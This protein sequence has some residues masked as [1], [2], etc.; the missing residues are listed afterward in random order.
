MCLKLSR[1]SCN[2]IKSIHET[3]ILPMELVSFYNNGA[4]RI[5]RRVSLT[6]KVRKILG[7]SEHLKFQT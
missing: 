3:K 4:Y 1:S 6:I 5:D 2:L 7:S